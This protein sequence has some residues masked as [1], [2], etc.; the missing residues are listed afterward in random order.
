[1]QLN[2]TLSSLFAL[3][4]LSSA[5][6]FAANA[7]SETSSKPKNIVFV[8]GDGMGPAYTTAYR[9]YKDDPNTDEIES[10][11]FDRL[12]V[13]MAR[14]S[15]AKISGY[16]TDSAASATALSAGVKTYNG[17]IGVDEH[18]QPVTTLLEKAKSIGKSIGVA[19]T[20]QVN[21]A[22]PASFLAHNENRRNYEQI[23]EDY[24]DSDA[25]VILGGGQRYFSDDLIKQFE[26]KGYQ[27]LNQFEQLETVQTGKV[28]GLFAD[29]QLPWVLD[30]PKGKQLSKMTDKALSLLSQNDK[31]FVLVVEGSI[32]DWAGHG[33]DIATAMAEMDEF[34]NTLA[35]IERFI[36]THPDTLMVVT[37]DHDTG[38][39]TVGANDKKSWN[40]AILHKLNA[41]PQ[42]IV[43]TFTA[44][45]K[46]QDTLV[47]KLG[48][49][50]SVEEW[51]TLTAAKNE[52]DSKLT[53]AIINL[54]NKRSNTGWTSDDHTAVD[55]QVFATGP[56][57]ELFNG[58]QDNTEISK[59]LDS[60]LP[61]SSSNIMKK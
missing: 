51:K 55:V 19:V 56:A 45:E 52:K 30:N 60:L 46:W 32:I 58:S 49:K 36:G 26:Q 37:A 22:T 41:S 50:P 5:T 61:H 6:T 8:I 42:T 9:Y 48:F 7:V 2:R 43:S 16:V 27:Y 40:P 54:V 57:S 17:A 20:S 25:D 15:P 13:G 3:T 53:R 18:K 59:K 21:H 24:L 11:I 10:T 34:A 39:L 12:L 47:Q 23:A 28:L 35:T 44:Q 31:G 1:M 38:G 4:L 33:N 14:T 29:V